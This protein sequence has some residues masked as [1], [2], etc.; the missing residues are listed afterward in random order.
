MNIEPAEKISGIAEIPGDK[1]ITHR[2]V[3]FNAAADGKA[4][5]TR[6]L[7]GEDCL[8]TVSC[9]KALGAK[10]EREGETIT[11]EGSPEF[12]NN[13]LC[14]C[15]NSG[16]TM[17]LLCGLIAGKGVRA[18]LTGDAS[19]STRPMRR[20]AEPLALLGANVRTTDGTAPLTVEPAP[21]HGCIVETG[22]ASA[23]VKSAILLAGLGASGE[24]IVREPEKSRD[25]S[26]RLLSAMGAD[27][28]VHQNAV[29]IR[30]SRLHCVDV[31]VPA[32]ISSAAYFLALGALKGE[33]V[34]PRVGVNPT[35]TGIL[36]AF[37]R[38]GVIYTL[39]NE[40]LVCGEPVADI[41]V[42]KSAMRA[43]TLSKEIMPALI[44]EIPVI[45]LLCA[46]AEGESV[47]SG[48][49][50]LKVKE[51]DRIATTAEMIAALGGDIRATD[52]GFVIRG[53]SKLQGG[54][55]RS[56][57]DHRIAMT[58]AIGLAASENG[59]AIE[60]AECV[61]ISF[62]DFYRRLAGLGN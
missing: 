55:V 13:A 51:S 28:F 14:D 54:K 41:V 44:D 4:K 17:R 6:A 56:Y 23:Q 37:D 16:T 27:I 43:I 59:G 38:L 21:L 60:G 34:C 42:K 62:P 52:D 45:A 11:V 20:V 9:M 25:H 26:E 31:D 24:T 58:A 18:T 39:Q 40:R 8:S 30:K 7:G 61:N 57:G 2:A 46:F 48:A 1:S 29:R 49:Q 47:I 35:R 50:E 10:I 22:V 15:G 33:I 12:K 53:K 3:M 32:D 19:L 5:I 36:T